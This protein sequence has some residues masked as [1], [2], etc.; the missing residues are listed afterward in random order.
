MSRRG[1]QIYHIYKWLKTRFD[2]TV[3][4]IELMF[5]VCIFNTVSSL[6]AFVSTHNFVKS[7]LNFN[8]KLDNLIL[9]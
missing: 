4:I 7:L 8:V 6:Y 5:F 3:M 9:C 1:I 2:S